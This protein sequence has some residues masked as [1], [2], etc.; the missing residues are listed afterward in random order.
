MQS[1]RIAVAR[2]VSRL[3]YKYKQAGK[4][5][6]PI[7]KIMWHS[8]PVVYPDFMQEARTIRKAQAARHRQK[9]RANKAINTMFD[10]YDSVQFVTLTF[11][12]ETMNNTTEKTRHYYASHWLNENTRD[13]LANIDYGKKNGREHYH[14]VAAMKDGYKPWKH[15]F[16]KVRNIKHDKAGNTTGKLSGYILKLVN[17]G[18]KVTAGKLFRK[19]GLKEVDNLPF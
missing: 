19:K 8:I 12:D 4:D 6:S 1:N 9:T 10:A 11:D 14:A 18:T 2:L 13:Y 7:D 5:Q 17:H 16:S 15:G 3:R